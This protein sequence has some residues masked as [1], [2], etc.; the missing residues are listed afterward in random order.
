MGCPV[1]PEVNSTTAMSD[2]LARAGG[3]G[4][5]AEQ[6]VEPGVAAAHPDGVDQIGQGQ[7]RGAKATAGRGRPR[8]RATSAAPTW[9]WRGA[10][11]APQR[12]QARNSTSA[13][14]QLGSCQVTTSPRRT[15]GRPQAAGR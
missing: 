12:Q 7:A 11:T 14:H 10:A 13:S 3:H 4:W 5:A 2:P 8:T 15:P 1:E 6:G 9:W